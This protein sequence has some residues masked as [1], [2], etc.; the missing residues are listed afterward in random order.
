MALT[1]LYRTLVLTILLVMHVYFISSTSSSTPHWVSNPVSADE[2]CVF[3]QSPGVALLY[4]ILRFVNHILV[5]KLEWSGFESG[6][7]GTPPSTITWMR[8]AA[9]YIS[10]LTTMKLLVV[11]LFALYPGIF[12]IGDWLLSWT[13]SGDH[14]AFQVIL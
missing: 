13:R 6:Q 8:Q 1:S 11:A 14:D 7:Y 9:V 5:D 4:M 12:K 10:A 3:T 2:S